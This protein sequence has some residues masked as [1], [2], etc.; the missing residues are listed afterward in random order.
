MDIFTH[1]DIQLR[2]F[3]EWDWLVDRS[4]K[5][6]NM[7]GDV[8]VIFVPKRMG[9]FVHNDHIIA[10]GYNFLALYFRI[11]YN[12]KAFYLTINDKYILYLFYCLLLFLAHFLDAS[13]VAH[14]QPFLSFRRVPVL[15]HF[16]EFRG[17]RHLG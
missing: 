2:L 17:R 1:H 9:D 14:H 11:T 4:A 3:G 16:L 6:V 8:F 7:R 13:L 5:K 10:T 15:G 12:N